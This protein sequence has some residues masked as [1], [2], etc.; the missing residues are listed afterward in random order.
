MPINEAIMYIKQF[1]HSSKESV[2]HYN[3][4]CSMHRRISPI[5]REGV[6]LDIQN[7]FFNRG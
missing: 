4:K 3:C 7:V 2:P 5:T 1:L 6:R